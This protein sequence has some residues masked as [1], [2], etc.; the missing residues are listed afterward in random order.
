MTV[1]AKR[2]IQMAFEGVGGL[3]ALIKWAE[4]NR[5]VFYTQVWIKLLPLAVKLDQNTIVA[6]KTVEEVEAAIEE[7]AIPM[8]RLEPILLELEAERE[9]E[10]SSNIELELCAVR[11][12]T[13][14]ES[15][16]PSDQIP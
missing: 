12:A 5:S 14:Q 2:A 8:A 9:H 4:A 3:P 16:M 1:E 7:R 11:S 15:K 13:K 10:R 6:Y